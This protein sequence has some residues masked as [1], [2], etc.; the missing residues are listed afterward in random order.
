MPKGV[1]QRSKKKITEEAQ[2][3]DRQELK[4]EES[5]VLQVLPVEAATRE[6]HPLFYLT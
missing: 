5:N 2:M 3:Q 1:D 6:I 4:K